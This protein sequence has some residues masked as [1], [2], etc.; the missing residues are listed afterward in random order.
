MAIS[1][2]QIEHLA[3]LAHLDISEAE[4]EKYAD[5]IS[6]ILDYF[7]Q[8]NELDT[9]AVEPLAQVFDLQNSVRDDEPSKSGNRN[10]VLAEAPE[11][12]DKQIKVPP[13]FEK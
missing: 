9:A 4:M 13:V 10:R 5:E 6:A 12:A 8:L 3:D 1:T 7:T 11:L 2:R